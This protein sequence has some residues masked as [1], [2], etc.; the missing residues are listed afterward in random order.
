[1]S[2]AADDGALAACF[3]CGANSNTVPPLLDAVAT[4]VCPWRLVLVADEH[5]IAMDGGG[6]L[7]P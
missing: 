4:K 6:R 3:L 5:V 7:Q 2:A 1:M